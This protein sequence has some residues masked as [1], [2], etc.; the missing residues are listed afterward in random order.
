VTTLLQLLVKLSPAGMLYK[1]VCGTHSGSMPDK[2]TAFA[3]LSHEHCQF[4]E[5]D[6]FFNSYP[7]AQDATQ[8]E[9]KATLEQS[10]AKPLVPVKVLAHTSGWHVGKVPVKEPDVEQ[11]NCNGVPE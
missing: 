5:V 11:V 4:C 10:C 6:P 1:Q 9:P 2:P 7:S 8:E 3:S